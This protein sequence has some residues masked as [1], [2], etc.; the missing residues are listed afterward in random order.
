MLVV[1]KS[2]E[3]QGPK[4]IKIILW[5]TLKDKGLDLGGDAKKV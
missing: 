5:P 3:Y 1:V 4:K 2:V